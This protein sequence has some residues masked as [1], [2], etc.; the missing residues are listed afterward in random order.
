M[1]CAIVF[2]YAQIPSRINEK[3]SST[4]TSNH[5]PVLKCS[6]LLVKRHNHSTSLPP[7]SFN[8]KLMKLPVECI[9][10]GF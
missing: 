7:I 6:A 1:F 2:L 5:T 10:F 3:Y 4:T 9:V 8:R